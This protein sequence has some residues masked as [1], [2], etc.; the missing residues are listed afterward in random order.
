MNDKKG[1]FN[2]TPKSNV[3]KNAY[4]RN[5]LIIEEELKKKLYQNDLEKKEQNKFNQKQN[6]SIDSNYLT[7]NYENTNDNMINSES[8]NISQILTEYL[9]E[10]QQNKTKKSQ[11]SN[12][13]SEKE[14]KDNKNR[15][16]KNNLK[17]NKNERRK[18]ENLK[19]NN[20][21]SEMNYLISTN[22][23][24]NIDFI[25]TL[26]KLKGIR[27]IKTDRNED[28]KRKNSLFENNEK[29]NFKLNNKDKK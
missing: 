23:K 21:S 20:N 24:E 15:K 5:Y 25:S 29:N 17:N 22:E 12:E 27:S 11:L 19:S 7:E 3:L 9:E 13:I 18:Y 14:I 1:K 28:K 8:N 4:K 16:N 6:K 26:L 2:F 10:V